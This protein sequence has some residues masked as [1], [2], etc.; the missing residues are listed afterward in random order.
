MNKK[1]A[2]LIE[3]RKIVMLVFTF[4]FSYLAII[5]DMS[6]ESVLAIFSMVFG[7]YFGKSTAQDGV[8]NE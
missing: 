5:G 7:Y 3:V 1:I 8:K 4:V 2:N 6:A